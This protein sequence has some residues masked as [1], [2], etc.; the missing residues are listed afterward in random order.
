MG[1]DITCDDIAVNI[2]VQH[3]DLV[4]LHLFV[5]ISSWVNDLQVFKINSS[6]YLH[7]NYVIHSSSSSVLKTGHESMTG[8][9]FVQVGQDSH[10]SKMFIVGIYS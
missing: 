4:L 5:L 3:Y 10:V 6:S 9:Y 8:M 1:N 2:H 7:E